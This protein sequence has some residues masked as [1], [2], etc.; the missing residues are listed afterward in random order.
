MFQTTNQQA[1]NQL[2]M[3]VAFGYHGIIWQNH[4]RLTVKHE[5]DLSRGYRGI[6]PTTMANWF[7]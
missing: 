5:H 4:G 1:S 6:S 2:D 7:V 3:T